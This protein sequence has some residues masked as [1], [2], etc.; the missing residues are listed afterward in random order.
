MGLRFV[1]LPPEAWPTEAMIMLH[2]IETSGPIT[3]HG[4]P[5][6]TAKP[7]LGTAVNAKTWWSISSPGSPGAS[8]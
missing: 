5:D 7:R 8:T 6:L 2:R 3:G 1:L 4:L